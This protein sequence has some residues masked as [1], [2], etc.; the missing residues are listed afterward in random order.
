MKHL[1]SRQPYGIWYL[2]AR[3]WRGELVFA[4]SKKVNTTLPLQAEA[5]AL[6][7][8]LQLAEPLK[9]APIILEGDTQVCYKSI[10]GQGMDTL[11]TIE[12]VIQSSKPVWYVY[13]NSF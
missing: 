2:L 12:N 6:L 9:S 11:W 8:A 3:D 13:L 7:R 10:T 1:P 5:E 4:C